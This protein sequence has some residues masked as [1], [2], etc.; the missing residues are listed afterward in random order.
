MPSASPVPVVLS[1]VRASY[2]F[3]EI[4][5]EVTVIIVPT[6]QYEDLRSREA[7]DLP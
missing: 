5:S 1:L 7:K 2:V 6:L 3:L 4:T